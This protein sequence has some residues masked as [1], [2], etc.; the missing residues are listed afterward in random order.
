MILS[1]L[2]LIMT[3]ILR[4]NIM[5]NQ[6]NESNDNKE[7]EYENAEA[8]VDKLLDIKDYTCND[9]PFLEFYKNQHQPLIFNSSLFNDIS[10]ENEKNFIIDPDVCKCIIGLVMSDYNIDPSTIKKSKLYEI[11]GHLHFFKSAIISKNGFN[12]HYGIFDMNK[13]EQVIHLY[14]QDIP[15]PFFN[16]NKL[17]M[18]RMATV[19]Y[20]HTEFEGEKYV[21]PVIG[22]KYKTIHITMELLIKIFSY[23]IL[24]FLDIF[25][26]SQKVGGMIPNP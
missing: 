12:H 14:T 23:G 20:C 3:E 8:T 13:K 24:E 9:K 25:T 21:V 1:N 2:H 10:E 22:K 19:N 18:N 5:V 6:A 11:I 15:E 4:E 26:L 7:F 16:V 17:T